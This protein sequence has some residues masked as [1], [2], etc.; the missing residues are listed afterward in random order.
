MSS[1]V[2]VKGDR[3]FRIGHHATKTMAV[4]AALLTARAQGWLAW[5]SAEDLYCCLVLMAMAL[6]LVT[7]YV[8]KVTWEGEERIMGVLINQKG[9]VHFGNIQFYHQALIKL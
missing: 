6:R 3:T 4:S 5:V 2:A 7:S 9:R 1:Q 8:M